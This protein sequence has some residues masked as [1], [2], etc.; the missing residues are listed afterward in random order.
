MK[1]YDVVLIGGGIIG[2]S[3]AMGL[4]ERGLARRGGRYRS[5]RAAELQREK[6]RRRARDLVA[7][8]NIKLCR[9]SI[10]YYERIRD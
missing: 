2:S 10:S 9:Q 8:V 7:A 6:R 1:R 4:A 3:A 5:E